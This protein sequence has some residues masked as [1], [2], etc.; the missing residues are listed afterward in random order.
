VTYEDELA[1]QY[2]PAE[3]GLTNRFSGGKEAGAALVEAEGETTLQSP[4]A[5]KLLTLYWIALSSSQENTGEA[6]ATVKLGTR[7]L[8]E[9]YL[10]NPGAFM[11]WEPI[12]GEAGDQLILKLS[13]A[14]K[15]AVSFTYTESV[16]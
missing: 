6:L 12:K 7:T 5:T 2:H 3:R 15:V 13:A 1:S 4:A 9:W 14:Q 16:V 10:G 8:Y 11:H